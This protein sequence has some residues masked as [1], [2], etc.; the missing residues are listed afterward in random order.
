MFIHRNRGRNAQAVSLGL[1]AA[2]LINTV[3]SAADKPDPFVLV[4]YSNRAGGTQIAS[5]EYLTATQETHA[6]VQAD[7][8]ALATNHCVAFAMSEQLAQAQRACDSAVEAA[9]SEQAQLPSWNPRS[10][11]Q[12]ANSQA[13]AYSNR[14]VLRWLSAD[15]QGARQ[16]LAR[17]QALAPQASFVLRNVTAMQSHENASPAS[18]ASLAKAAQQ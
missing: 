6:S 1:I 7:P 5:G 15:T 13:V 4:A 12:A 10:H 18:T 17:A 11:A 3:V 14:A 9:H 2:A 8:G 16:D